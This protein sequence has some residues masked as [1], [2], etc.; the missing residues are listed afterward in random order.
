LLIGGGVPIFSGP[1]II[2]AIGVGGAGGAS[3]DE[4]CALQ[5]IQQVLPTSN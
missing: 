4:S 5:A 2:G 3:Q 1:N